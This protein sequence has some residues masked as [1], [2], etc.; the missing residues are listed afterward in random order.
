MARLLALL[1]PLL[2]LL[3][4]SIQ[5]T[6]WPSN[7]TRAVCDALAKEYSQKLVW[8]P[9]GPFG[10]KTVLNSGIYTSANL[11]YWNAAS[12]LNRASCAFFPSTTEEVAFAVQELNKYQSVKFALKS[13]GHNPN[14]GFSSVDGGV[15]IAFRPNFQT[16]TPSADGKTVVIGAGCK[17][18]DVY[19]TL[20][21]LG[22]TVT[23]GRLGDVGTTGLTLGG[24][25]SYLSAQ[26]VS[27]IAAHEHEHPHHMLTR[28]HL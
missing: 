13:G 14:L 9:L 22:K 19:G 5:A 6:Y 4:D 26:H 3:V 17:W 28:G 15:L 16:A 11:D 10:I 2:A 20:Q 21:P 27:D 25:L 23:G 24:G 7:D 12:S 8:D 18:E 1:L